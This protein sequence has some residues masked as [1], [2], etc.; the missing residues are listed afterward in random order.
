MAIEFD[1][2][3]DAANIAKHGLS[4]AD[5]AG[6]DDVPLVIADQRQDY[7]E[8]RWQAFGRI[9]GI[10]CCLVYTSRGQTMRLI[11]LRRCNARERMRHG[12]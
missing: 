6:F 2:V 5:F 11:S 3:K 4:L 8:A 12:L 10:A 9:D 1:P 7:G